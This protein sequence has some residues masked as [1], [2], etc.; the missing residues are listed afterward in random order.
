MIT[1]EKTTNDKLQ[2]CNFVK[3][4][5]MMTVVLYHSILFWN[6]NWFSEVEKVA[7]ESNVLKIFSEWLNT[8][9]I[10]AFTL[11]SG[12][13]FTYIKLEKGGYSNFR[14]FLI[15]KF[16]RLIVPYIFILVVWVAPIGIYIFNYNT[17]TIISK[18]V[19]GTGPNQLWFLLMLFNVF[20]ISFFMIEFWAKHIVGG[21]LVA[22]C[23]YGIGM[24]LPDYFM[25]SS[26]FRFL[27]FFW[28]GFYL[29]YN[30]D[31]IIW[32]IP[33]IILLGINLTLFAIDCLFTSQHIIFKLLLL[34]FKLTNQVVGAVA[35]FI[36]IGR[37]GEKLKLN[38]RV[39]KFI[40]D[41]SMIVYMF[42][43][44][45]IYFTIKMFNGNINPFIHAGINF[46]ISFSL[47]LILACLFSKSRIISKLLGQ[48]T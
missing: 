16:S 21:L 37:I 25:L 33:S 46:I 23:F 27:L 36:V 8:F 48:R 1:C 2:T 28:L 18:Y 34:V 20:I 41:K 4:I 17:N 42:H 15:N 32:K 10:Y 31:S 5:L 19:L 30:K 47:S 6:G 38:N 43:Q 13:I 3:C 44:Q 9:H 12:Y 40:S 24:V 26:T 11:V 39:Y 45:F 22:L 29:R 35:A 7:I 14:D